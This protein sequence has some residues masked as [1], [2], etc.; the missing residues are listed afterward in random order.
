MFL[1]YMTD[2]SYLYKFIE[3]EMDISTSKR[4][5]MQS[6]IYKK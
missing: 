6:P 2:D 1:H 4:Q 5:I 3:I